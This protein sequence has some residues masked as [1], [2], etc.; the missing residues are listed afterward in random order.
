MACWSF[1]TTEG[2]IADSEWSAEC[3]RCKL[4]R[5]C[6]EA[7]PGPGRGKRK[8][9]PSKSSCPDDNNL[10]NT[11]GQTSQTSIHFEDTPTPLPYEYYT[12]NPNRTSPSHGGVM[13]DAS[14]DYAGYNLHTS[15]THIIPSC[16]DL[17]P[18]NGPESTSISR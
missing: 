6:I 4:H 8:Y 1:T 14:E 12:P 7:N 2:L 15:C 5:G 3:V 10:V 18:R 11:T 17:H 16:D 13:L 9:T